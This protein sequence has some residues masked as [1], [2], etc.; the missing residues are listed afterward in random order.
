[1]DYGLIALVLRSLAQAYL[2][3]PAEAMRLHEQAMEE[4]HKMPKGLQDGLEMTIL[5]Y[6]AERKLFC[7]YVDAAFETAERSW[8]QVQATGVKEYEQRLLTLLGEL[9]LRRGDFDLAREHFER[10]ADLGVQAGANGTIARAKLGLA[11]WELATGDRKLGAEFLASA[12]TAAATV[13]S[14]FMLGEA[15]M[16][17]G[18]MAATQGDLA[19]AK[20]RF[21]EACQL[22]EI[23]PCPPLHATAAFELSQVS[24]EAQRLKLLGTARAS[25]R[26]QVEGLDPT[27]TRTYLALG[28]RH[29]ILSSAKTGTLALPNETVSP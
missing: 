9:H 10:A 11:Q 20:A 23:C 28:D 24:D 5:P 29:R 14:Q 4:L 8:A 26:S 6:I 13:D 3:K 27:Q 18:K 12:Y 25:M 1:G 7:G 17:L 22:G 15:A 19:T 21:E 2:G 16:L